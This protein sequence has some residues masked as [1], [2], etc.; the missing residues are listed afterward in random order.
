MTYSEKLEKKKES[1]PFIEWHNEKE[2]I[3]L[4]QYT[5]DNC[6]KAELIFKYLL[7]DLSEIGE[8]AKEPEK[9]E[10]FKSAVLSLNSLNDSLDGAFIETGE[11]EELCD[12]FDEITVLV[13][14]NP[15][16]YC[17]GE[18]IASEWRDW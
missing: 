11:R 17:D 12:L 5:K 1:L 7:S 9:I 10:K 6:N 16:A 2:E 3:G 18:G 8:S 14:M 4:E 15:S 13:G